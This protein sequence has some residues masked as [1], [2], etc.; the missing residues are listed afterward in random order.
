MKSCHSG[1]I[2]MGGGGLQRFQTFLQHTLGQ[3]EGGNSSHSSPMNDLGST[4]TS[5]C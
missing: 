1:I 4:S 3:T 5:A 2:F